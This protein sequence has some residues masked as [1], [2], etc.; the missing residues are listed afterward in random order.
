MGE[1][2]LIIT[3]LKI[4]NIEHLGL[5]EARFQ[6]GDI[7]DDQLYLDFEFMKHYNEPNCQLHINSFVKDFATSQNSKEKQEKI[8]MNNVK[9]EFVVQLQYDVC[10]TQQ[11]KLK[12]L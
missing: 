6:V 4:H 1:C 2:V 9:T 10:D 8:N 12:L 7:K 3:K 11:W 5:H